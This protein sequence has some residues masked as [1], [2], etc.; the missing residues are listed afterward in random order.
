MGDNGTTHTNHT[1]SP[2]IHTPNSLLGGTATGL[3]NGM[4]E[5]G[6]SYV[7]PTHEISASF[8]HAYKSKLRDKMSENAST[9]L[10]QARNSLISD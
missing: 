8:E 3:V 7:S 4:K 1:A 10:S 9:F 5:A 6:G 2:F